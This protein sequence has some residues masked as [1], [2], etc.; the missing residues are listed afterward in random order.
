MTSTLLTNALSI[1]IRLRAGRTGVL[2]PAGTYFFLPSKTFH[3]GYGA[4]P[5]SYSTGTQVPY[6]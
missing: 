3:N 1:A 5:T 6:W 2:I 4:H